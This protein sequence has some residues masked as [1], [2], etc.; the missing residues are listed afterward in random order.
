MEANKKRIAKEDAKTKS[1]RAKFDKIEK[2]TCGVRTRG[3]RAKK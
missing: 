1:G 2:E 3:Q